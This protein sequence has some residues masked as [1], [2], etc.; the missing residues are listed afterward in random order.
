MA[1][2]HDV[3]CRCMQCRAHRAM[4]DANSL[5]SISRPLNMGL[6]TTEEERIIQKQG[7]NTSR[8][9]ERGLKRILSGLFWG[10]IAVVIFLLAESY[11]GHS[12]LFLAAGGVF[13]SSA[14]QVLRGLYEIASG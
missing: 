6:G 14:F 4:N 3:N 12:L 11:S 13:V 10:A 9:K 2:T 8:R 5:P 1:T 7:K